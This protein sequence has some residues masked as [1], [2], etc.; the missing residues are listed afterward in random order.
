M[1]SPIT[2]GRL[3]RLNPR[4]AG[5]PV[6][7]RLCEPLAYVAPVFHDA[8]EGVEID[9]AVLALV[10]RRRAGKAVSSM[11]LHRDLDVTRKTAWHLAMRIREILEDDGVAFQGPVEVDET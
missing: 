10:G 2:A 8:R 9:T 4:P 7:E 6:S 11:K 3:Y 1:S 5:L